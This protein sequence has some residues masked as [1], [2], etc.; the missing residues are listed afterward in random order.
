MAKQLLATTGRVLHEPAPELIT[1]YT[2]NGEAQQFWPVDAREILA[3]AGGYTDTPP[4]TKQ[5]TVNEEKEKSRP[6][7]QEKPE[8][9]TAPPVLTPLVPAPAFV[10]LVAELQTRRVKPKGKD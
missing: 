9:K 5:E 4:A 3:G 10:E 1:L 6:A 7:P 8:V 2:V